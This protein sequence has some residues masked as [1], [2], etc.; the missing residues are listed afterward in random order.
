MKAPN[1]TTK[2]LL[3]S[4]GAALPLALCLMLVMTHFM[5]SL[6][7]SIMLGTL[8]PMA[9]TAAQNVENRLHMLAERFYILRESRSLRDT[10]VPARVK[11]QTLNDIGTGREYAWLG[12]YEPD[13]VLLTGSDT[14]PRT[15]TG[16]DL[17]PALK[18][19]VN[20]VVEKTTIGPSGPEV[21]MGIPVIA[22][23]GAEADERD[24]VAY[25]LVGSYAY[26]TLS[27]VLRDINLGSRGTAFI[28]DQEGAIIAHKDLGKIFSQEPVRRSLGGSRAADEI[29]AAMTRRETGSTRLQSNDEDLFVAYSPIKGTLWVLG[30]QAPRDDF[31]APARQALLIGTALIIATLLGTMLLV[32]FFNRKVLSRP[33]AA[34]TGSARELARGNFGT[35]LPDYITRRK[36][37]I[38]QLSAA[39]E[40][41]SSSV[42]NLIGDISHLATA[43]GAG[44]LAARADPTAYT[45]DFR[46]IVESLN[47]SLGSVCSYLD[48]M[49]DAL[50]L[51]DLERRHVYHNKAMAQIMA[52]HGLAAEEPAL[53]SFISGDRPEIAG[54]FGAHAPPPD[55]AHG[56]EHEVTLVDPHG[57]EHSYN[58]SLGRLQGPQ[59]AVC[60]MLVLNDVS[61]LARARTQAEAASRAK[62][63][64][65]SRMSHEM[66]TP[67]NAIIG[68]T[69]IGLGAGEPERKQY[70]LEK[71]SG[72]SQHLLGII[73]DILD[74]SKI[75]AHKFELAAVKFNIRDMLQRV[76]DV[77][78]FQAEEQDFVIDIDDNLPPALIGDEQRLAQVITNLLGNAFKFT[79]GKGTVTLRATLARPVG[80]S[81]PSGPT[82]GNC[83]IRISIID[84]G[85]GMNLEQQSRLFRPF[86]Q[87]DGG[88]ARKYGGT[89]LGLAISK[90]IVES[91]GGNILLASTPGEG[92]TF[93]I[94]VSLP[95]AAA[96]PPAKAELDETELSAPEPGAADAIEPEDG[97]FL[98]RRVL[99]AED[100]DINRE[101]V[102]AL[103][104]HTGLEMVF[105]TNGEEAVRA[106]STDPGH[107]DL[108]L[109]DLQ[110]PEV[111]GFEATRRIRA[112]GL[113]GA[114]DIP[115]IAMTA[116][117]FREDV[118]RCF[119]AGMN[120]HLGKPI[121]SRDVIS[122]LSG[123]FAGQDVN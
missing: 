121:N 55:L 115:I 104:E 51:L 42:Q 120:G 110:M 109:M 87:A 25:Y 74:M 32:G 66:R 69:T 68:M 13:G 72:A 96:E 98:G 7:D 29:F 27:D 38:G 67:M 14:C 22:G 118:E 102:G 43:T 116:N 35:G 108:I 33:L 56:H 105:A 70:C 119:Q 60:V 30:I 59:G 103:L 12:L 80:Q 73:N 31:M 94:E 16:R 54:L 49:P 101:I 114:T 36:D 34:I 84:T 79:P 3:A 61:A 76:V 75:E 18:E 71:I 41:L 97:I 6:T 107:F 90:R 17:F 78:R 85:I 112:S 21:V 44:N 40:S 95:V 106:F 81:E 46:R 8:Q 86:E 2:I 117:V 11:Q 82:G 88:I 48:G 26:D 9:R 57:L 92:S 100:V 62:G 63:D 65:L 53:F 4:L 83:T 39:F 64:F 45:G 1:V 19:T 111:D 28:I 122:T 91:M 89:G 5:N 20:L 58:L 37:E 10:D 47:D 77:I 23:Y 15:I 50:L 52:R 123:H 93:T 99:V 113:P 24:E